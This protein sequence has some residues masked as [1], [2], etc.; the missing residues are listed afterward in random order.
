MQ[1]DSISVRHGADA[2]GGI[3]NIVLRD[4]I[5]H[6]SIEVRYGSA[7]GGGEERQAAISAGVGNEDARA[8]VILDYRDVTPLFGVERDLWRNQDYRRFGS[9]DMRS[10]LSSPGNVSVLTVEGLMALGAPF[11]AI[12]EHTAGADHSARRVSAVP[13]QPREPAAVLPDR[14]RGPSRQRRRE[15]AGEHH[16]GSGRRRRPDGRRSPRGVLVDPAVVLVRSCRGRIHTTLHQPV[17]VTELLDGLIRHGRRMDSLLIRGAGSL[18]GK[19]KNWDWELSLLRSEEDA[20]AAG[21]QRHRPGTACAGP[22]RSRS[23]SNAQSARARSRREPGSTRE[24]A[25]AAG[26]RH[27]RDRC[28]AA[29]GRRQR[30][31][32]SRCRRAT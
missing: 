7:A 12:P 3:I 15:R 26:H 9:S 4:D 25:R 31:S 5:A 29:D 6:P 8:A 16:A 10:P 32:S 24:R 17:A 19:V 11:A 14:H 28:H 27:Y 13:A 22:R 1:L 18:R 21:R 30:Q 2:I 23:G 20:E